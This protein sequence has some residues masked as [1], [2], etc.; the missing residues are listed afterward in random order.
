[1][2]LYDA[3]TLQMDYETDCHRLRSAASPG[4]PVGRFARILCVLLL[5][6][7]VHSYVLVFIW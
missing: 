3:S 6:Q 1:M 5:Q 4:R 2:F 7:L